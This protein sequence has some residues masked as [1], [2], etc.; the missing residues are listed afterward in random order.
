MSANKFVLKH[1]NIDSRYEIDATPEHPTLI[2]ED[3]PEDKSFR[4]P[5]V[6]MNETSLGPIDSVPMLRPG[7]C[8]QH[9]RLLLT[10]TRYP[11]WTNGEISTIGVRPQNPAGRTRSPTSRRCGTASGC[12][13]RRQP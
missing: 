13:A 9:A 4:S 8:R 6:T 7:H 12:T 2:Y 1:N 10:S 5:G 11:V 3:G